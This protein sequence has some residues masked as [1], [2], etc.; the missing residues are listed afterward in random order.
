MEWQGLERA[1][2]SGRPCLRGWSS[3][4]E[5]GEAA[6]V[7]RGKRALRGLSDQISGEKNQRGIERPLCQNNGR[8]RRQR[9]ARPGHR[10]TWRRRSSGKGQ[11]GRA[12]SISGWRDGGEK[13]QQLERSRQRSL[14]QGSEAAG[15]GTPPRAGRTGEI[16]LHKSHPPPTISKQLHW[17]L[18]NRQSSLPYYM[19]Q[20]DAA[21][22]LPAN[23]NRI[24]RTARE[25]VGAA[26]K[27]SDQ[28]GSS[29]FQPRHNLPPSVSYPIF[30]SG[31][32]LVRQ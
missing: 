2:G 17:P 27:F 15:H 21:A 5:S 28:T 9:A 7:E 20:D 29:S 18:A 32:D 8:R 30:T 1:V 16:H 25:T 10:R 11:T 23:R 12:A 24:I 22:I 6:W 3:G 26:L 4:S 14:A 19:F 31:R 13:E